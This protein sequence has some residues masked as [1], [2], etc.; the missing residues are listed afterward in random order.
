MKLED[1]RGVK[2]II[3]EFIKFGLLIECSSEYNTPILPVKK[4]DG[5]TYRLAQ[6][7]RAINQIGEHLYPVVANPYTLLTSLKETY[8]WFTVL[9]LEDELFCLT[10][11][12]ESF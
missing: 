11:A 2:S 10:L 5:K 6:D 4:P 12:P 7:L 1:R 8:E 9:D 3:E